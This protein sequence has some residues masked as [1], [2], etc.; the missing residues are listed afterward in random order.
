MSFLRQHRMDFAKIDSMVYG[1]R[2]T[3]N[4]C[5]LRL[6]TPPPK[7]KA[8]FGGESVPSDIFFNFGDTT[9]IQNMKNIKSKFLIDL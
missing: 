1:P 7:K 6:Q 3:P 8:F 4:P 9:L 2:H 5:T